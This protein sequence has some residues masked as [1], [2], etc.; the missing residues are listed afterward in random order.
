MPRGLVG[1]LYV[2]GASLA[3]FGFVPGV[4]PGYYTGST[5]VLCG[6]CKRL[7]RGF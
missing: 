6:F 7:A 4:T 5:R 2:G 3:R 1:E